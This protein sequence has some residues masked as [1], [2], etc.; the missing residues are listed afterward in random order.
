MRGIATNFGLTALASL[1]GAIEHA[2]AAATARV[3]LR[4]R[5]LDT[6]PATALARLRAFR[7]S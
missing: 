1:T 7:P 5:E 2:S 3:E 6:G 4:C